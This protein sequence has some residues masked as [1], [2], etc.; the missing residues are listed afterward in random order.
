L[1][2]TAVE[3]SRVADNNIVNIVSLLKT[4]NIARCLGL[5]AH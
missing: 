4:K 2:H 1:M 5:P 3:T